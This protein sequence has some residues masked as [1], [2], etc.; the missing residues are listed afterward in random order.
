LRAGLVDRKRRQRF[1]LSQ[2]RP[3][4]ASPPRDLNQEIVQ[5]EFFEPFRRRH[6]GHRRARKGTAAM[7]KRYSILAREIGSGREIELCQVDSNPERVAEAAGM[8]VLRIRSSGRRY[9]IKRYD[10]IR[11]V[12][13]G[14]RRCAAPN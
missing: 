13:N 6:S 14:K 11:I 1:Q 10:W 4:I 3:K 7:K 8:K 9:R 12:D 2:L 5:H